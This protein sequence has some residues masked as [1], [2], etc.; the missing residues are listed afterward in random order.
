MIDAFT[1]AYVRQA[2]HDRRTGGIMRTITD[3]R[4]IK[5]RRHGR[6][7][8]MAVGDEH[9]LDPFALVQC[10]QY[11]GFV[12][13]VTG[14][15]VNQRHRTP[16][17]NVGLGS[18]KCHGGRVGRCDSPQ[19]G[20]M[21]DDLSR[22]HRVIGLKRPLSHD[23]IP[24]K[25]S[26]QSSELKKPPWIKHYLPRSLMGRAVLILL[27]PIVTL[28]IVVTGIF[29][30]R[31]FEG[32]TKQL[33]RG[34]S[35]EIET[36]LESIETFGASQPTYAISDSLNLP[37]TLTDAATLPANSR[38]WWDISG[39]S[40]IEQLNIFMDRPVAIDLAGSARW[41][42]ISVPLNDQS[43]TVTLHR[44]RL[45]AANPHQLI[46]WMIIASLILTLISLLFLRNQI[47]PIHRLAR[48]AEAFGKGQSDPFRPSGA[49]EVRR[50]GTAFLAMRG[51]IERQIDQRTSM[52]SGVSHDLRTPL[53]RL[54]LGLETADSPEDVDAMRTDIIEMERMLDEFLAFASGDSQENSVEIDLT[55]FA[56]RLVN[57]CKRMG[58]N[59]D[60][61][62][63]TTQ[64]ADAQ[65]SVREMAVSRAIQNLVNNAARYG[66]QALLTLVI[67]PRSAS[68]VIED[69]GP[70]IPPDRRMEALRP[71]SRLD[72]ARNQNLGG[73]VGLGL[74][75]ALDV[76]RSHG[77]AL[78]L[79][80]SPDLG[81]LRA[82]FTLPR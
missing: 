39:I 29:V 54:K 14:S 75:I 46:W 18:R 76:A 66:K 38:H 26:I 60:F 34:V 24:R 2:H 35:F 50:A 70:G 10:C 74:S 62:V 25:P 81:G 57:D 67:R 63:D 64:S 80:Q 5:I 21:L 77:G 68:F 6:M 44:D 7:I 59:V 30:Q 4:R 43:V 42:D 37:F 16:S 79:D 47:R 11:G 1:A 28:Q 48:A 40:V 51:R 53:T 31:H 22:C 3:N 56:E 33:V 23:I 36:L 71:F 45:S 32:V 19:V 82:T 58:I 8:Q 69:D 9:S 49:D 13:R 15:G 65:F 20:R 73:G 12:G 41:V 61:E 55:D 72:E 78:Q 27:V 52:L 17:K